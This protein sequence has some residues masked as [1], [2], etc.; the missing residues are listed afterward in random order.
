M[1][2][3]IFDALLITT[4]RF[5]VALDIFR[6]DSL[7]VITDSSLRS[8]GT[9]YLFTQS[10]SS[11]RRYNRVISGLVSAGI[12]LAVTT[13]SRSMVSGIFDAL[14]ITTQRFKVAANHASTAGSD[15]KDDTGG[16]KRHEQNGK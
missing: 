2:S 11:F 1:V 4:Q 12:I 9:D 3:G 15:G 7:T 6:T 10:F 14:L 8:Q 13:R 16:D 5:K